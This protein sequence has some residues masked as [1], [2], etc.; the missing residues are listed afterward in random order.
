MMRYKIVLTVT[1]KLQDLLLRVDGLTLEKAVKVYRAYEQSIK[2][3][4]EFKDSS[5][6]SNSA[7]KVNKVAQKPTQ[8]FLAIRTLKVAPGMRRRTMKV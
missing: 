4:K 2:Q 8:E 5:N 1:G 3:V 7:T 6:P